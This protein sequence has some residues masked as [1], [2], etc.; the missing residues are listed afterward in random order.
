[1]RRIS[2]YL[3]SRSYALTMPLITAD[4]VASNH[5]TLHEKEVESWHKSVYQLQRDLIDQMLVG[6]ISYPSFATPACNI[7]ASRSSLPVYE[8]VR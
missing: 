3:Y 4:I 7:S 1:M 2:N 5:S 8:Y 6:N